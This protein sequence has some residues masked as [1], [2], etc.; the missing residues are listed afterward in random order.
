MWNKLPKLC[1]VS[2][3]GRQN[4]YANESHKAHIFLSLLIM[5]AQELGND[6]AY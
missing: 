4:E 2:Q 3:A 1:I 5:N 6:D